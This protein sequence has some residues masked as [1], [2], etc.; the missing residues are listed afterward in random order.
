MVEDVQLDGPARTLRLAWQARASATARCA[1]KKGTASAAC[2]SRRLTRP[3]VS[4]S[5][6]RPG[7]C[8]D[9]AAGPACPRPRAR[10]GPPRLAAGVTA[11]S[12]FF[13]ER[14]AT[15]AS[16]A[17]RWVR[18]QVR[19]AALEQLEGP[20]GLAALELGELRHARSCMRRCSAA[21]ASTGPAASPA[22]REPRGRERHGHWSATDRLMPPCRTA[23]QP[24][25]SACSAVVIV[26][27]SGRARQGPLAVSVRRPASGAAPRAARPCPRH[28]EGPPSRTA[29]RA[30]RVA[31]PRA[32]CRGPRTPRPDGP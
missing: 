7:A 8:R 10:G 25:R 23:H 13:V 9:R 26:G 1:W 22:A 11:G 21:G 24:L 17:R 14:T 19:R 31:R 29:A 16:A 5:R 6:R 20:Y 2:C 3:A 15:D 30:G 32:R 28:P 12:G 4:P 18:E 27:G